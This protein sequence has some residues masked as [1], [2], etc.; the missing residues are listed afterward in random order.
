VR[1]PREMEM[2]VPWQSTLYNFMVQ[3]TSSS[4]SRRSIMSSAAAAS[5]K[6]LVAVVPAFVGHGERKMSR[7]SDVL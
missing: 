6:A 4:N 1:S 7:S 2:P 3:L 5:S